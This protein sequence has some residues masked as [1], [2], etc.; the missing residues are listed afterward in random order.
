MSET[1][2]MSE[3]LKIAFAPFAAAD[4]GALVVFA[5][6]D[7]KLGAN[8][9]AHLAGA[10]TLLQGAAETLEKVRAVGIVAHAGSVTAPGP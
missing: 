7:L 2:K 6:A 9:A 5:G 3:N 4:A 10:S 8:T 1:L